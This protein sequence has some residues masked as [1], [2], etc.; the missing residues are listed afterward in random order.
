V[1]ARKLAR[2]AADGDILERLDT[3]SETLQSLRLRLAA[4]AVAMK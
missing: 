4:V 2:L 1:S 3:L